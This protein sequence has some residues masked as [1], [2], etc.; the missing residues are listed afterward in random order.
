MYL[1][2][3]ALI[4]KVT[5]DPQ[6]KLLLICHG[7]MMISIEWPKSGL[8][9]AAQTIKFNSIKIKLLKTMSVRKNYNQKSYFR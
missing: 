2:Q 8:D 4:E 3:S 9:I 5:T 1:D 6:K 7:R